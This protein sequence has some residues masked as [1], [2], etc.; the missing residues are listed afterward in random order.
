MVQIDE[1]RIAIACDTAD[2]V[3]LSGALFTPAD[4]ASARAQLGPDGWQVIAIPDAGDTL[5]LRDL[6]PDHRVDAIAPK[7]KARARAR[8]PQ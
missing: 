6:C 2:T 3:C 7:K 5:R 8:R 4:P 1:H